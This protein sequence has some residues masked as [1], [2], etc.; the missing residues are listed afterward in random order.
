V[1][2]SDMRQDT[3]EL[4]LEKPA[5]SVAQLVRETHLH[6]LHAELQGTVVYALGVDAAGMS[7][8]QWQRIQEFWTAY[9]VS[10]KASLRQYSISR[11]LYDNAPHNAATI[12]SMT[13]RPAILEIHRDSA[14][15]WK[16]PYPGLNQVPRHRCPIH[17]RLQV[18]S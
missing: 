3:R 1:I 5:R 15:N 7:A 10:A 13:N 14:Q 9:F 12:S 18:R 16:F 11:T 17:R 8:N 6:G 4:T 2:F